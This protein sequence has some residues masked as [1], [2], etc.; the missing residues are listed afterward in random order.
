MLRARIKPLNHEDLFIQ[1]YEWLLGWSLQ[2]TRHNR[3]QAEDLVHDAFIQFTRAQP[4][5]DSIQNIEGYLYATLKNMH[6]SQVRRAARA[7]TTSLSVV[8]FDSAEIG[9]RLIDPR[10]RIQTREELR[11]VCHYACSRKEASKTGSVLILRF[12]HGYYPNEIAQI[13]I[14]PRKAVDDWLFLGRRDAKAYLNHP[15]RA[16]ILRGYFNPDVDESPEGE[17]GDF[18][19]ELRATIFRSR[20]GK[21]WSTAQ[22]QETYRAEEPRAIDCTVLAHIVSCS[23][24]LETVNTIL[25]LPSLSDRFP[26]DMLGPDTQS[27]DRSRPGRPVQ[28]QAHWSARCNLRATEVFEHRPKELSISVNGFVLGSQILGPELSQQVLNINLAENIGFV[29]IFSEQGL[30]LLFLTTDAPPDGAPEQRAGIELSDGRTLDLT[31][32]FGNPWPTC[33]VRYC[34]PRVEP[35]SSIGRTKA[36]SGSDAQL[37]LAHPRSGNESNLVEIRGWRGLRMSQGY[38]LLS[39]VAKSGLALV[40]PWMRPG[41]ITAVL[42]V[43]LILAVLL[44]PWR[45]PSV[46]AAEILRRAEVLEEAGAAKTGLVLHRV[47]GVEE[48]DVK[49]GRLISR[50]KI[51]VWFSP[52]KGIKARRVYD[53][54]GRLVAA[55]WTNSDGTRLIYQLDANMKFQQVARRD[56]KA[57]L[58]AGNLWELDLSAKDFSAVM[59]QAGAATGTA[60]DEK[61]TSYVISYQNKS[62]QSAGQ[63]SGPNPAPNAGDVLGATIRLNKADLHTV[64]ET[65]RV[66]AGDQTVEYTFS[67]KEFDSVAPDRTPPS[68]FQID[69][70]LTKEGKREIGL[71]GLRDSRETPGLGPPSTG[72]SRWS[73]QLLANIKMDALYQLHNIGSCTEDQTTFSRTA[74]GK[75]AI[76]AVVENDGRKRQVLQALSLVSKNPAVTVDIDTVPEAL[77]R[78]GGIPRGPV[79]ARRV[80]ITRD[81]IPVYADLREYFT[82]Q[83]ESELPEPAMRATGPQVDEE[84]RRFASRA[85]DHSRRALTQAWAL[86]RHME[87]EPASE[88]AMLDPQA[89]AKFH[90]MIAEHAAALR[91]E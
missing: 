22:L 73:E 12:F 63:N 40:R 77:K 86:K 45:G 58:K 26:T 17:Q 76:Q 37:A 15:P 87:E 48:R 68:V 49:D 60:M 27:R 14:S 51:E 7:A 10:V 74:E 30:R 2:F 83:D 80:E 66:R 4:D 19:S 88:I 44:V 85:L 75:L 70:D 43:L 34:D 29:E 69:P 16:G 38:H 59:D 91:Q 55:E 90:S 71:G 47:V 33:C 81:Q 25:G 67:E 82:H 18:L 56:V 53:E 84:V 79:V 32:T 62:D 24:C 31:L 42:A 35:V 1:R 9:L 46:S 5:L 54:K 36:N 20:K 57:L 11:G 52:G 61:A 21:C 41:P 3:E 39:S 72:E 50:N 23:A 13:L 89:K 78:N 8:D 64:E 6:L 28:K 65:L